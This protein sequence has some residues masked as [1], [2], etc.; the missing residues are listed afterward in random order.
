MTMQ[1]KEGGES[2]VVAWRW[3]CEA[4]GHRLQQRVAA[5]PTARAWN[6]SLSLSLSR[7]VN[8]NA[9]EVFFFFNFFYTKLG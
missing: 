4:R 2:V 1:E 3:T 5:S 9:I 6:C 7:F 8:Q